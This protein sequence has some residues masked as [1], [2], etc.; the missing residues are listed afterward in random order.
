L[1]VASGGNSG[2]EFGAMDGD[3]DGVLSK[4][5]LQE[6]L[7]NMGWSLEE[8]EKTFNVLD[9]DGIDSQKDPLYRVNLGTK[10]TKK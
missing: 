2:L 4:E 3:G 9:R 10:C 1:A 8:A 5:E 7:H 6:K